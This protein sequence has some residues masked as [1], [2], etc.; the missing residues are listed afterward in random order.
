[1]VT[2]GP[3][4]ASAGPPD[5]HDLRIPAGSPLADQSRWGKREDGTL[6]GRGYLG[7]LK[8]ADGGVSSE[9]SMSSDIDGREILYPLLVPTLTRDEVEWL[10]NNPVDPQNV[11]ASIK[12]KALAHAKGRLAAGK[13]PFALT[14]EEPPL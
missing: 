7:L 12:S 13:S 6:K 9:L 1:P 2:V 5:V 3:P 11:P 10:L 4:D 8:R 14:A